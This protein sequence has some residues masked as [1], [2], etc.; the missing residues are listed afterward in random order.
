[1]RPRGYSLGCRRLLGSGDSRERLQIKD[2][3]NGDAYGD[4]YGDA[5]TES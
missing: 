3:H 5:A 1:M 2:P 4:A